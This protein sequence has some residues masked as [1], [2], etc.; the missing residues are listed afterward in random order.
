MKKVKIVGVLFLLALLLSSCEGSYLQPPAES[1]D[2]M[3]PDQ[4][5]E[6]LKKRNI[7][8]SEYAFLF[9]IRDNDVKA[10]K[11]FLKAGMSPDTKDTKR[12]LSSLPG[13]TAFSYVMSY[14]QPQMFMAMLEGGADPN[15]AD[16]DGMTAL[17]HA[18]S[19]GNPEIVATLVRKGAK[20]NTSCGAGWS[21]LLFAVVGGSTDPA[22]AL[23][24][25]LLDAVTG[26][27]AELYGGG[28][29]PR[30]KKPEV[31]EESP[32]VIKTVKILLLAGADPNH[33]MAH[34]ETP[35]MFAALEGR[36][37]ITS[38]LLEA[39]AD[40]DIT[41]LNGET[42]TAIA[43]K[44]QRLEVLQALGNAGVTR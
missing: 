4:A 27:Q 5:M 24:G 36:P 10:V 15:G 43:R 30:I 44:Y 16:K 34:G 12:I 7:E 29:R 41:N 18:A 33:Q 40:P 31:R 1:V 25:M 37:T 14:G 39:G 28:N 42:A 21:P 8:F 20:V 22:Q 26:L 17:M 2:Q 9:R 32:D 23:T 38:M 19:I 3:T 11:L 6:E 35:L 13:T